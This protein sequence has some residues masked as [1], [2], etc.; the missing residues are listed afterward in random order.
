MQ[1]KVTV[2]VRTG[3]PDYIFFA[4]PAPDPFNPDENATVSLT[5]PHKTGAD[6]VRK[7]LKCE[8]EVIESF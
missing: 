2:V 8:P 5:A 4:Y 7:N 3:R 6:W 1:D